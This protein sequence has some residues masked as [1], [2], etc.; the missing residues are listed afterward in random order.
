[1]GRARTGCS[2]LI[3]IFLISY[4]VLISLPPRHYD[5]AVNAAL[6]ASTRRQTER[7]SQLKNPDSNGFLAPSLLSF[8][9][10][11]ENQGPVKETVS[12][13]ANAFSDQGLGRR[14]D[15][16]GLHKARDQA[17]R[18]SRAAFEALIPDL[19]AAFS[20]PAFQPVNEDFTAPTEAPNEQALTLLALALNGY[21]ESLIAEGQSARAALVY[22]M[23]FR[24]GHLLGD[25]VGSVQ[26]MI[27]VSIQA[28]A[29]QSLV[30]H[31]RPDAPLTTAQWAGLSRGV[32]AATPTPVA[33]VRA[34]END[35][36]FGTAFLQRPRA[37]YDGDAKPLRGF[38]L[39]PG[40]R[41][42]DLRIYHNLMG[43]FLEEAGG[44]VILKS[45]PPATP[46]AILAGQSGP[47]T[48]L[49]VPRY[50]FQAAR[51]S[52]H[53]AKMCGLAATTAICAYRAKHGK[54]PASL[55][56]L[57][58]LGLQAP[59]GAPWSIARGLIYQVQGNSAVLAVQVHPNQFTL[60][61]VDLAV[62]QKL[63]EAN[64]TYFRIHERG[65][66]FTL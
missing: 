59:G 63:E 65:F 61:E 38:Y 10:K 49:L 2:I 26:S 50:D 7:K 62:A 43:A 16:A 13:W 66:T 19:A 25:D 64:S 33:L 28:L 20:K 36:A 57:D 27:G 23:V 32:A 3:A 39:I 55:A 56:E 17:Y 8:W 6:A 22:E 41:A 52:L 54:L 40:A 53:G 21:A 42:R 11:G 30:A 46:E 60:A 34:I 15:H 14:V 44:G 35:L 24:E 12:R 5:V 18:E 47:G 4:G 51:F 58:A 48:A 31:L 45:T 29:F 9:G 37:S 1:M